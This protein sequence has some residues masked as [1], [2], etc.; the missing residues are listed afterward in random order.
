MNKILRGSG[1]IFKYVDIESSPK[2]IKS[3]AKN[4]CSGKN[5]FSILKRTECDFGRYIEVDYGGLSK[6]DKLPPYAIFIEEIGVII[7][8]PK[9]GIPYRITFHAPGVYS[10]VSNTYFLD[11][12]YHATELVNRLYF[13]NKWGLFMNN[14]VEICFDKFYAILSPKQQEFVI[15]N[16]HLFAKQK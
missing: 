2:V 10:E 11:Y 12:E 7:H 6:L 13:D 8:Y 3:F 14:Y 16:L 4:I 9:N 15:K 1:F 5:I